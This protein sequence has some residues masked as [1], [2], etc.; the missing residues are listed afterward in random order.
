MHNR[1]QN[2]HHP[3]FRASVCLLTKH[4]KEQ[5]IAPVL[6]QGLGIE[7]KVDESF[8]T[9]SLGNFTRT[10]ARVDAQLATAE[11][12]ARLAARRSGLSIGI[13]SEGSFDASALGGLA[14]LNS[15][16]LV[17]F[18]ANRDFCISA[19]HQTVVSAAT[20]TTADYA[21]LEKYARESGF[22]AQGIVLRADNDS[23]PFP[24]TGIQSVNQLEQAFVDCLSRSARNQVFA[25]WD[26]RAHC[27]PCRMHT[28]GKA[29][30]QLLEH[31]LRLCPACRAPGY[32]PFKA[33]SGLPCE[34]CQAPTTVTKGRYFRCG[35]CNASHFEAVGDAFANPFNCSICN[36]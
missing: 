16:I 29:A 3:Y 7:L 32:S 34:Q 23:D 14:C 6:S 28:I 10:I 33:M 35:A 8:D 20:L 21:K 27:C 26:F 22:P 13:G 4:K 31:L 25:E 17:W 30:E 11:K 12:K 18:D 36:P 15:E 1:A 2:N 5:V 24:V 19:Q 9:D